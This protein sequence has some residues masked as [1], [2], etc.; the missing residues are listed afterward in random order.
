[1]DHFTIKKIFAAG[2][3]LVLL[4]LLFFIS[5]ELRKTIVSKD[6]EVIV[7]E[8]IKVVIDKKTIDP[9]GPCVDLPVL[10]YHHVQPLAMAKRNSQMGL[11]ISPEYFR[12][13]LKYIRDK[14]YKVVEAKD[15]INY[16]DKGK[17]LPNNSIMI[18]FDDGYE[19]NFIYMWPIL[20][21]FGYEATIFLATGL[22]DNPGYLSW[23]QVGEMKEEIY[24]ANHTQTHRGSSENKEVLYDEIQ[25]SNKQLNDRGLDQVMV[26]AYPYGIPSTIAQGVL[27]ELRYNLAFTT[28]NGR[29]QCRGNRLALFRIRTGNFG[30][31][32][33]GL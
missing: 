33:S 1:M 24:F 15:L 10:I 12:Q 29:I 4:F 27:M 31:E 20:R 30:L 13:H 25:T 17:E 21:E 8:R 23:Q 32:M 3:G 6:M 28:N 18:T 14:G 22:V 5:N 16:F 19:D 9:E 11:T 26:F 2:I 7:E